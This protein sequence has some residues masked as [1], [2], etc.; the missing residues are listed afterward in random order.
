MVCVYS[1]F[2]ISPGSHRFRKPSDVAPF[3][4]NHIAGLQILYI[5]S[6]IWKSHLITNIWSLG[7]SKRKSIE[8]LPEQILVGH[9]HKLCV[10]IAQ[11]YL[12]GRTLL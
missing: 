7:E 8:I 5:N 6:L 4:R 1:R 3:Q 10:T 11:A 9:F 12:A 2:V